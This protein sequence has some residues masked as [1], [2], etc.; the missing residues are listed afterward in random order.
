[1]ARVSGRYESGNIGGS[2][3]SETASDVADSASNGLQFYNNIVASSTVGTAEVVLCINCVGARFTSNTFR[4]NTEGAAALALYNYGL[5][6]TISDNTFINNS[7]RAIYVQGNQ[8]VSIVDNTFSAKT[9][10]FPT[11]ITLINTQD[12]LISGNYIHGYQNGAS[13][14]TGISV[15]DFSGLIDGHANFYPNTE[16]LTVT[17]NVMDNLNTVAS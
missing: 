8:Y 1:M 6:S 16:R 13:G 2:A 5:N 15:F 10:T 14:S 11:G 9:G 12:T 4:D 7:I 17:N 3:G